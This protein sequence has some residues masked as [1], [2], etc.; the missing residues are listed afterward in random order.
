M[1]GNDIDINNEKNRE[2]L[3]SVKNKRKNLNIII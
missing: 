2:I 1:S 3:K